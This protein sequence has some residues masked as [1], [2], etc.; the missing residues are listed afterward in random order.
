MDA[1]K[2]KGANYEMGTAY[3]VRMDGGR[4]GDGGID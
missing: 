1:S 4:V 3:S 2:F